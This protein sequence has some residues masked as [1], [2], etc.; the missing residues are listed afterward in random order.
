MRHWLRGGREDQSERLADLM[1]FGIAEGEAKAWL[2][3]QEDPDEVAVFGVWAENAEAL[4]VFLR[5][6]RQWR[7][8]QFSGK[9]MGL[10]HGAIPATLRLMGVS[11]KRWP[12][13]FSR[14]GVCE[15]VVLG[16]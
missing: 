15:D 9:P 12:V 2:S 8:H 3:T 16:G 10:D 6:K 7:L 13:I 4:A 1:K 11:A 5:L 14:L